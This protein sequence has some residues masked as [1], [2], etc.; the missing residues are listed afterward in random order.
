MPSINLTF[1]D[2]ND[3]VQ[4]GDTTYYMPVSGA[5]ITTDNYTQNSDTGVFTQST[6]GAT[7]QLSG[8][9]SGIV[10]IGVVTAINRD[11]STI[12]TTIGAATVRP[13]TSDYIFFSK[14]NVA[15]MS[16]LLGYYAEVKFK[17]N[18]KTE[19]EL[20]ALGSEIVESSK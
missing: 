6:S 15:N 4:I 1:P 7:S 19:A 13:T 3:S 17:N 12:T 8:A 5:N 9:N 11:T 14:D 20:F 2:L 18:S 10:E 16:S